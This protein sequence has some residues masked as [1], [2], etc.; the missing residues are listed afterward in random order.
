MSCVNS[1][2]PRLLL[3]RLINILI[4]HRLAPSLVAQDLGD[5]LGEGGFA[6]VDV[7]DGADIYV[8]FV[9]VEGSGELGG[10]EGGGAEARAEEGGGEAGLG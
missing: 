2:L 8:G 3:R 7:A 5:G 10:E 9:A 6:V 4:A 1:N